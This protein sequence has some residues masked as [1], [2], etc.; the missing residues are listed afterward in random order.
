MTLVSLIY[1][2]YVDIDRI[3]DADFA[4]ELPQIAAAKAVIFDLR[5]YPRRISTVV[6]SHLI[7]STITS[8]RWNIPVVTRPD[9][10]DMAFDFSNWRVEPRTPRIKGRAAFL[11]DGS[12]I[13]AVETYLGMVE[14]YGLA[15]LVGE[16]TAG[17]NGNISTT[18]LPSGFTAVF[19]GMK[20]LKHDQSRHHG[21][22][23]L[24][25]V[26][27]SPT[28]AGFAAGRDEQLEKALEIVSR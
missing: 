16:P 18:R 24:P 10:R 12:A 9:G 27:V 11:I 5:G 3:T 25:T 13:S 21:V 4:R 22:G 20:V 19:T 15:E 7:D 2:M 26:P 6:L 23:I 28:I 17:T 8:L 1:I 14:N